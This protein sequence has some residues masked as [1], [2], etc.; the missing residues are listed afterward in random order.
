MQVIAEEKLK[1]HLNVIH[2]LIKTYNDP[3][4]QEHLIEK[5]MLQRE[6]T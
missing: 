3:T 4:E 1:Y 6:I 5:R 2:K